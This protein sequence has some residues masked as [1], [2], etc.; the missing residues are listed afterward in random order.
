MTVNTDLLTSLG[1]MQGSGQSQTASSSSAQSTGQLSQQEFLKLMTT[2]LS[3][4]DPMNPMDNGQFLA[5]IAQFG[6]VSGIGDLNTSFQSLAS[7]MSSNQGLQA[8]SLVGHTVAVPSTKAV[9]PSQGS[10][11]AAVDVPE[12]TNNLSVDIV[13]ADGQVVKHLDLGPT[14]TG[15]TQFAWDG[16]TATGAQA[17]PGLYTINASALQGGQQ[18]ALDVYAVDQVSSVTLGANGAAPTLNLATLG[19]VDLSAVK[20]IM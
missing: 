14:G 6:T 3:N 5:Q 19:P 18:T 10:M 17:A 12:S 4:Q 7:S 1:L 9:L 2:Q 15:L 16:T 11:M 8:S 13:A 20:Q